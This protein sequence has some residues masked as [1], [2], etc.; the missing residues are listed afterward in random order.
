MADLEVEGGLDGA[1][2]PAYKTD[3]IVYYYNNLKTNYKL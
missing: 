2:A 1:Q 3:K